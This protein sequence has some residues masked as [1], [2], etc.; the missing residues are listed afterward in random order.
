MSVIG[1]ID[2][3]SI[4]YLSVSTVAR[5]GKGRDARMIGDGI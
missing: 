3:S 1:D 5:N 2:K 4:K